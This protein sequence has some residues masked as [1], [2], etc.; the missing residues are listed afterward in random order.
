MTHMCLIPTLLNRQ[1][2]SLCMLLHPMYLIVYSKV[3]E[4]DTCR[5]IIWQF[6]ICCFIE[7]GPQSAGTKLYQK[8]IQDVQDTY[9]IP[10]G[11]RPGPAR[12]GP[13]PGPRTGPVRRLVFCIYLGYLGYI[14]GILLDRAGVQF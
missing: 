12:P 3:L 9:K 4:S 5:Q 2:T 13:S 6:L 7:I 8:Y 11:S 10:S 14:F 1:A